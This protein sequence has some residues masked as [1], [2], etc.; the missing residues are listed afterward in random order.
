MFHLYGLLSVGGLRAAC[1]GLR[2]TLLL[3]LGGNPYSFP[4]AALPTSTV[5][6]SP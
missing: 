3:V 1:L 2:L 5:S 4:L 6:L